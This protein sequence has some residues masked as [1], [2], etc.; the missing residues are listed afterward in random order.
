MMMVPWNQRV[1]IVMLL[2]L[3]TLM[4]T[5][6]WS[7]DTGDSQHHPSG[8]STHHYKFSLRSS[9]QID[10]GTSHSKHQNTTSGSN[11]LVVYTG[12][13]K[14]VRIFFPYV[15]RELR[16]NGGVLDRVWFMMLRYDNETYTNLLHLTQTANM[17]LKQS[18]FEM[19]FMGYAPGVRPPPQKRYAAPYNEI[20][21][22]LNTSD[23]NTYFKMDDDIVYIHPG[24]FKNVIESKSSHLCFLHFANIVT[25]WR[26]NIK[27]QELG[28][29]SS[30]EKVNPKNLTFEF[31]SHADC[32]WKSAECAELSL[33]TFLH[34]YH[35]K[36]LDKYQFDGLELLNQRKRFSINLFMLDKDVIDV[37]VMQEVGPIQQDDERWWS[38]TY[39]SEFKQPNCIVGGGLVVH[40]SYHR[41][42]R[43][44]MELGLLR[45]FELIVQKEVGT[46][47]EEEL[48]HALKYQK[49]N[50]F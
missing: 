10:T 44:M 7:A 8:M 27:H 25:N 35:Q 39:A 26:C 23:F 6:F 36:E 49:G 32:G 22:G 5:W 3:A 21:A 17:I 50:D 2:L 41:S 47:M 14:F 37:K 20:F 34:H 40:F 16:E 38:M 42:Y 29:Y 13:W 45:E 28:V 24:T 46:L 30:S 15:Y 31:S 4:A 48:W 9:S 19:H 11:T 1:L 18:V 43:A 12:R 33:R